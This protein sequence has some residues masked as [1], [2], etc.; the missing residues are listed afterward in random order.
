MSALKFRPRL[1]V[2]KDDPGKNVFDGKR[3][4]S[5]GHYTYAV[6]LPD[7]R[8]VVA[9]N[10]PS[11][12]TKSHA[13]QLKALLDYPDNVVYIHNKT[14]MDLTYKCSGA[15]H[16]EI[17]LTLEASQN[18][19]IRQTTKDKLAA[20]IAEL[21]SQLTLADEVYNAINNKST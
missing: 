19:R 15:I 14:D 20:R 9:A 11:S 8:L 1:N 16:R 2:F 10:L 12:T 4:I 18:P 17:E 3:A 5:Y 6:M 7:G 21:Q 13:C